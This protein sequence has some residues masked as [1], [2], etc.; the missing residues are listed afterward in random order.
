MITQQTLDRDICIRALNA[1]DPHFDGIFFVG[2]ATTGIYCRPI[3]PSRRA[4]DKNRRFFDSA[5]AAER[6]G[7]RPCLRCRPELAPGRAPSDAVSRLARAAVQRISA[8]ALND[9]SV[10]QLAQE[11]DVSERH[12]R[13]VL[14]R[15]IGVSPVELAQTH[16]LLL[17]KR[18]LADTTLPI[19]QVA[20]ASGFGS[21]RRFNAVFRKRYD[22]TPS[23]LRHDA[24]STPDSAS[25]SGCETTSGSAEDFVRLT[26]AY[27]TPLAWDVLVAL[28]QKNLLPGVEVVQGTRYGRT[29]E[30]DGRSGVVF[31]EDTASNT[32]VNVDVS[33]SLLPVLMPVLAR[34]RQ[35]FDLDAQPAA[36]DTCLERGGLRQLVRQRPGLRIPGTFD[37]FELAL[38]VLLLRCGHPWEITNELARRIVCALG[39]PLKTGCSSLGRLA[40]RAERVAEAGA[41]RLEAFGVPPRRA[42]TI[43]E[44]ARKVADGALRLEP[45]CDVA[46]T[47][48]ALLVIDGLDDRLVS[49]IEMR[50]LCW[51]DAFPATDRAL[52]RVAGASDPHSL[53]KQA[54]RWRPWRA[55]AA[56]HLW[57]QDNA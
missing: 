4:H 44:V 39:E 2:I 5:A 24:D 8:G 16:R 22:M 40:P 41:R 47:R 9:R 26:L 49:L 3:C 27:R 12:L 54:E 38:R 11:F 21:L 25:A 10:P 45:G 13:R 50:A 20:Y 23:A 34:L 55:Y 36:V 19:T 6:A 46:A 57:L 33:L 14:Q 31:V 7:F 42:H 17:A 53:R 48:Q 35:L 32:H 52:Q 43:A 1:R 15:E 51:P 30:V 37:G 18:L 28:L 56:L 29:V